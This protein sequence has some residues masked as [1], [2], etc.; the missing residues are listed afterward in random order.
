MQEFNQAL[1]AKQG[2]R[3]LHNDSLLIAKVLKGRYYPR[4]SFLEA[5]LGYNCS[6]TWRSI[7]D[8]KHVLTE[9]NLWRIGDGQSIHIW[10]DK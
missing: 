3:L 6:Y 8:T 4:T 2:W 10:R 7:F 1:L 9:G 5:K